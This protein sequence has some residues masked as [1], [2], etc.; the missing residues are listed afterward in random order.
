MRYRDLKIGTKQFI[1]FGIIF[2]F[3][4]AVSVFAIVNILPITVL[5]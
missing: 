2:A 3:M 5:N 1:G 4:T